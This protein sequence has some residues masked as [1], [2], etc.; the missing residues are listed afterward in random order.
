MIIIRHVC[1]SEIFLLNLTLMALNYL[2]CYKGNG[3][4]PN[5][6]SGKVCIVHVIAFAVYVDTT[7]PKSR[8]HFT[9]AR[10]TVVSNSTILL[11]TYSGFLLSLLG[12]LK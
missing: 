10:D 12:V 4:R 7:S 6:F 2:Q 9:P 5:I 3:K 11:Y 8:Q 1:H